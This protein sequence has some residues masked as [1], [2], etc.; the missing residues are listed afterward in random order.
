[1]S[2]ENPDL[3]ERLARL[4]ARRAASSGSKAQPAAR[5]R[6][7]RADADKEAATAPPPDPTAQ[8][9]IVARRPER[10][11]RAHPAA[12]GRILAAGLSTSAFLSLM[13][14]FAA[15]APAAGVPV[16][17]TAPPRAKVPGATGPVHHPKPK[18]VTKVRRHT[19]YVDQYGRPYSP[20]TAAMQGGAAAPS[21]SS[22]GT[23]GPIATPSA[24][25]P[26][27][28]APVVNPIPSAP[29]PSTPGG[30]PPATG[31]APAPTPPPRPTPAPAPP[32]TVFTPP[33]PPAPPPC[34]GTK[35]P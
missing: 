28:S 10:K 33:P 5:P 34:S 21:P 15:R 14:A 35:C 32:T 12:A 7:A 9:R 2:G 18:V 17:A 27:P 29:P 20:S 6:P 25:A 16:V 23:P 19:V 31:R 1:M 30:A 24:V 3:D 11:R 8:D 4:A 26:L 22:S 13:A